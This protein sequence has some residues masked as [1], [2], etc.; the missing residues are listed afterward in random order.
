VS[1]MGHPE[2]GDEIG[3]Q[4]HF[5]MPGQDLVWRWVLPDHPTALE[6]HESTQGKCSSSAMLHLARRRNSNEFCGAYGHETTFEEF[7]WLADWCLVRGVN[8]LIPHAFYY[9]VRGPRKDERPP[10][11]GG[12]GCNWWDQFKPFADHCS[13]LSWLNTDSKHVCRVGILTDADHC[14]WPA[15]KVCFENQIDFNYVSPDHLEQGE[16]DEDGLHIADLHYRAVIIDGAAGG[17]LADAPFTHTFDGDAATLVEF[18]RSRVGHDVRVGQPTPSLRVRHVVK[19]G[20]HYYLLVNESRTPVSTTLEVEAK[21]EAA[22]L[23]TA[24]GEAAPLTTPLQLDLGSYGAK[25]LQ[26]NCE[27]IPSDHGAT[28]RIGDVVV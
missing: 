21:G 4:R 26:V 13:R 3:V 19:D 10:Q 12:V 2:R 14:P 23:D 16:I 15:A 17:Q 7:K 28:T 11:V 9:S 18:L 27:A 22:W 5:H 24:T 8:L 6:G 1:L 25:L 20:L